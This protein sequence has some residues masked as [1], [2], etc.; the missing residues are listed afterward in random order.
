M[1]VLQDA[2][3]AAHQAFDGF[4]YKDE[5]AFARWLFRIIE[6]RLRDLNDYLVRRSAMRL[7][8]PCPTRRP[9]P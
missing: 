7:P 3:L 6:N 4:D 8:F 2:Y 1:D 5:G 9:A